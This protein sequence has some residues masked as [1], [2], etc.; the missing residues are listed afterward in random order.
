[1]IK[2]FLF[3]LASSGLIALILTVIFNQYDDR[4]KIN[5]EISSISQRVYSEISPISQRGYSEI[6]I[7]IDKPKLVK[8]V[9]DL[10]VEIGKQVNNYP[11]IFMWIDKKKVDEYKTCIRMLR[12]FREELALSQDYNRYLNNVRLM[13]NHFSILSTGED[14]FRN[15]HPELRDKPISYKCEK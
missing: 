4:G 1:M 9:D 6:F 7:P 3:L 11:Y 14:F 2:K 15:G 10:I 5:T 12:D 13:T 8:A